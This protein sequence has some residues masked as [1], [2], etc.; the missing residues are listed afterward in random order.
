VADNFTQDFRTQRRN[1]DDGKTRTDRQVGR[2]WYSS[3]DNTIRVSDGTTPGGIVIAGAGGG[4]GGGLIA[5]DNVSLLTNDAN[6]TST[7]DNLSVFTND[8]G[9]VTSTA[10]LST[11]TNDAGFI[12]LTDLS[13]EGD[14]T[15]NNITGKFGVTT[16]KSADFDTDLGTK[17]TD[18]VNEGIVNLYFT[19]G[20]VDARVADTSISSLL[21]VDNN[22]VTNLNEDSILIYNATNN[23]FVAES[24]IA[25]LERLKAEL[26]V[27]YDRLV[28]EEGPLTYIGEAEPGTDRNLALWRIKRVS[29]ASDGDL[30]ILWANGAAA[31]DKVWDDRAT[32]TYS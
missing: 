19:D 13:A 14:L 6:Y 5:G 1:Y 30:E 11:F 28:D 23:E 8:V 2:L 12:A 29:E 16:Y 32:Y 20:R 24:F 4:S 3:E 22:L 27:Q 9:F 10:N 26:E 21:D 17:T 25:V 15:Y 7:G 18:D 31:F